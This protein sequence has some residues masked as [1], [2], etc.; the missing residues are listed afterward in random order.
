[1]NCIIIDD[2]P[3]ARKGMR[4]L[5]EKLDFINIINEFSSA[6]EASSY[7]LSKPDLDIIFLDIEMPGLNGL[8]FLKSVP[9]NAHVILTT[10]YPQY[11][12]EAFELQVVDY[13]L[14]PIK[15]DRFLKAV[16]K[17]RDIS[18]ATLHTLTLDE[19]KQEFFYI[20]ADRKY[21]R[22]FFKDILY[23]KGLKDYVMIYTEAEKYMTAMNVATILRNLPAVKFARVSKSYIINVDKINHIDNDFI[24]LNDIDIPL[25]N[26]Y[27]EDFLNTYVKDKLIG[28]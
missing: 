3:L 4:L 27:K 25:G 16:N 23:I 15:F 17:A 7:L 14:K 1:M 8:E 5:A 6:I 11:A 10:A 18:Q 24:Y 20:K 22:L 12:L 26:T 2:E 13:L 19:S 21:V 28:R 9:V